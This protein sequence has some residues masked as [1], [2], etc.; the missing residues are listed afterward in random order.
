MH[1]PESS[2]FQ[3]SRGHNSGPYAPICYLNL[4]DNSFIWILISSFGYDLLDCKS[5][6]QCHGHEF[7]LLPK[8]TTQWS[9]KTFPKAHIQVLRFY[10]LCVSCWAGGFLETFRTVQKD[11]GMLAIMGYLVHVSRVF[12]TVIKASSFIYINTSWTGQ[13]FML[14]EGLTAPIR[15]PFMQFIFL[16]S[17]YN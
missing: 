8:C 15:W 5:T 6:C 9:C 11:Y 4:S 14:I 12:T 2:Y 13:M 7:R 16:W 1:K 3:W 10:F 17:R